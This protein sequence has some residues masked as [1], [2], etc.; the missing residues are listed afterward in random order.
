MRVI[1]VATKKGNTLCRRVGGDTG[2]EEEEDEATAAGGEGRKG[3]QM[4]VLS[5]EQET[6]GLLR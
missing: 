2:E 4:E 5:S 3:R 1:L 6:Q